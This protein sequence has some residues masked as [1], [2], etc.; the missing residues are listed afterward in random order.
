M[1]QRKALA[2]QNYHIYNRHH[3]KH[4][5]FLNKVDTRK[6]KKS[7]EKY[8]L[9]HDISVEGFAIMDNH[10]H[11]MA[12]QSFQGNLSKFTWAIQKSY[13]QYYNH[14][15]NKKGK[16]FEYSY[17][18]IE[19]SSLSY[20]Q[21]LKKYILLNPIDRILEIEAKNMTSSFDHFNFAPHFDG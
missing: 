5:L 11:I 16:V 14:K 8:S 20:Y 19:I 4:T 17:K 6:F 7:I 21:N 3:L 2:N 12:K 10:F 1:P 9:K 13:S 18:A 15:Y